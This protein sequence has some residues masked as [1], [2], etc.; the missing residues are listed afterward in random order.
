VRTARQHRFQNEDDVVMAATVAFGMG[1][2][3]PDVRFVIHADPPKSIEAYWQEVGRAGRD[4]APAEGIAFYGAGD[5]RRSLMWAAN[6]NASEE[7]RAVQAR[8]A[9]QLFN[10]LDGLTCRRAAIRRY[11]GET[12]VEPC[13][14]CDI[15][16]DPPASIDVT[17]RAQKAL[18]AVI[19]MDQRFGR[20]RVID[21]LRGKAAR[22]GLDEAY[23]SK[24][25]Y[26]VGAGVEEA[27]WRRIFEQLL[28]D[29]LLAE[30]E[31]GGRPI[32]R[33]GDEEEVRKVFRGARTISIREAAPVKRAKAERRGRGAPLAAADL[34]AG[35][36][37]LF[38]A[39]RA[40]RRETAAQANVP[41]YVILHDAT[42][43]A[44][45]RARPATS[46]ALGAI[47]GIGVAKL[48]KYG[49]AIAALVAAAA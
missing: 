45:A 11:F 21:H 34:D 17:E 20:G 2:D 36:A 28:F 32:L 30:D 23:L 25:T 18:S 35:Q 8:K 29:G 46:A 37:R 40:W 12:G 47:A 49:E 38:E 44:I 26:G 16:L 3:K 13:G 14:A 39:L 33:I 22:D 7:I 10:F 43:A 42:L 9:R 31:P 41:P 4:G 5:L 24:S 15:C 27:E 6:A 19:R 48:A 1:V